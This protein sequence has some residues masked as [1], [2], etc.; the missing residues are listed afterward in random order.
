MAF[1]W[2]LI[3]L[4]ASVFSAGIFVHGEV[5]R[6]R[7]MKRELKEIKDHQQQIMERVDSINVAYASQKLALTQKTDTLYQQIDE[8]IRMKT[9]NAKYINQMQENIAKQRH[10]LS[11]EIHDLSKTISQHPVG[12]DNEN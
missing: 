7:D 3:L 1:N 12:I 6:R 2:K 9:L 5:I 4:L 8:I 11:L 10:E